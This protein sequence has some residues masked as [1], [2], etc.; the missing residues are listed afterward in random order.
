MV[1]VTCLSAPVDAYNVRTWLV[2][3]S[4][5][6]PDSYSEL[7]I[8]MPT[9]RNHQDTYQYISQSITVSVAKRTSRKGA[10]GVH[11]FY[12]CKCIQKI[13]LCL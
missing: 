5:G 9:T 8:E 2:I 13:V 3:A 11:V 7:G 10:F 4:L 1:H 6:I 12:Q